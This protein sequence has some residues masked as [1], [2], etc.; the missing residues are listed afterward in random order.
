MHSSSDDL[1]LEMDLIKKSFLLKLEQI[2]NDLCP[3]M[4]Q[5]N[6]MIRL[7]KMIGNQ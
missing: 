5:G 3:I 6:H 4:V 1:D 7:D 2:V